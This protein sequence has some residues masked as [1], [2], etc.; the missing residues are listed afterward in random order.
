MDYRM[1]P[2]GIALLLADI[3]HVDC[4]F[5]DIHTPEKVY[6]APQKL[7]A[8]KQFLTSRQLI[9]LASGLLPYE[10]AAIFDR[11]FVTWLLF[12]N[13]EYIFLVGPFLAFSP[14]QV[15]VSHALTELFPGESRMAEFHNYQ[16]LLPVIE[17]NWM[18]SLVHVF[19]RAVSGQN[20]PELKWIELFKEDI[21]NIPSD[22]SY[23][24]YAQSAYE[25]ESAYLEAVYFGNTKGAITALQQIHN[26]F[27]KSASNPGML[28]PSIYGNAVN[29]TLARIAAYQAG[30][31]PVILDRIFQEYMSL[32]VTSKKVDDQFKQAFRMTANVCE[33][34]QIARTAGMGNLIK[35]AVSYLLEHFSEPLTLEKLA[36]V[37]GVNKNY[38]STLFTKETGKPFTHYLNDIRLEQ[39][40]VKIR[41]SGISISDI[42]SSVGIPDQNY[43]SRL[44][45][46]KY[47]MSP[48]AWRKEQSRTGKEKREA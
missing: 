31:S 15:A 41:L 10:M 38:L 11:L 29:C 40:A 39:A 37:A 18:K 28:I 6:P 32:S 35:R 7:F 46:A 5:S 3:F 27:R 19:A 26:R 47:H 24:D 33:Q 36:D 14:N 23:N 8:K 9:Q 48:S 16:G 44:F 42:A 2:Q 30:V 17:D 12:Q 21:H 13:S 25:T 1:P 4:Q 22:T 43:F 34:V 45:R 20:D